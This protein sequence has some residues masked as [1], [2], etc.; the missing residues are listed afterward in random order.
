RYPLPAWLGD[1]ATGELLIQEG[2]GLAHGPGGEVLLVWD[3]PDTR[4]AE[5]ADGAGRVRPVRPDPD[6]RP[7]LPVQVGFP[8]PGGRYLAGLDASGAPGLGHLLLGTQA[9]SLTLDSPI[10]ALHIPPVAPDGGGLVL[11]RTQA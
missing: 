10:V 4:V 3:S 8:A 1:Q 11:A 2:L 6:G 9:I 5:L 7:G